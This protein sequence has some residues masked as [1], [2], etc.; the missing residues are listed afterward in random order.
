MSTLSN[1]FIFSLSILLFGCFS[2]DAKK[3]PC[4]LIFVR[5]EVEKQPFESN[6]VLVS[7]SLLPHYTLQAYQ[8]DDLNN[9]LWL[10]LPKPLQI[11]SY[12]ITE[13]NASH[14]NQ[15]QSCRGLLNYDGEIYTTDSTLIGG[16]NILSWNE[17]QKIMHAVF[18]FKAR[19]GDKVV[20]VTEGEITNIQF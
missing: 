3:G 20:E 8:C 4:D 10:D 18:H 14:V 19:S 11:G 7:D 2:P 9:F 17:S 5:F 15:S 12:P 6:I 1:I 16:L 13:S